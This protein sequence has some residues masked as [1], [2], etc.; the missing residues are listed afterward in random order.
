MCP[1]YV[2][3]RS[4]FILEGHYKK[5]LKTKS[6]CGANITIFRTLTSKGLQR[7]IPSR[8]NQDSG[9]RVYSP[10]AFSASQVC[11]KYKETFFIYRDV[12]RNNQPL[13]GPQD[14]LSKSGSF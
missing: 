10:S 3:C 6:S 5:T 8:A 14:S 2:D 1:G 4:L 12:S 9:W 13:V 7:R 11:L